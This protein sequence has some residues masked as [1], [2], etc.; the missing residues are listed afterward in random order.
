MY[1]GCSVDVLEKK[2]ETLVP[3]QESKHGS[4]VVQP[5]A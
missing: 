5:I 1:P 3:F 2:K 4:L